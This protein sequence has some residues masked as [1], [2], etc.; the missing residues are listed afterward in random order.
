M[1][2]KYFTDFLFAKQS[3]YVGLG[4]LLDLGCTIREYNNSPSGN[5]ADTVA[6]KNDWRMVGQDLYQ[7]IEEFEETK[8]A[9]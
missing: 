5:F 9:K 6:L 3:F 7:S 4:R 2:N 1:N 8:N